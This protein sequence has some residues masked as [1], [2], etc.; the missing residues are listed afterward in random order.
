MTKLEMVLSAGDID[1]VG[2]LYAQCFLVA[3]SMDSPTHVE[4]LRQA[5]ID[6]GVVTASELG[7]L[8]ASHIPTG[9][10]SRH[11][12]DSDRKV[13]K[14]IGMFYHMLKSIRQLVYSRNVGHG[15][16]SDPLAQ[17]IERVFAESDLIFVS[18][19]KDPLN[20][21]FSMWLKEVNTLAT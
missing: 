20:T 2:G 8:E 6:T 17:D 18:K 5:F 19:N 10:F 3:K 1:A 13:P 14:T 12:K 9:M 21:S 7:E 4:A 11:V 15:K 16:I